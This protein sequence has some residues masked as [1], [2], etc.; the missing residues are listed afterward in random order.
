MGAHIGNVLG[1]IPSGIIICKL[2]PNSMWSEPG[3]C[4]MADD[5]G[6][7]SHAMAVGC[8]HDTHDQ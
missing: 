8:E 7:T 1:S 6:L 2:V 5:Q 3:M 4:T